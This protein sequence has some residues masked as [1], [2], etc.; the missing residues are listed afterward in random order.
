[1][2]TLLKKAA[3][4]KAKKEGL[5]LSDV[6]NYAAKAYINGDIQVRVVDRDTAEAIDDIKH[7]RVI[8]QEDLFK[9]L[10]L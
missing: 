6:L 1:M 8:S 9:K 2:N 3:S 5:T 10:G 4:R 7:G